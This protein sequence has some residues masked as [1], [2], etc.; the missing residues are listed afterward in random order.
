STRLPAVEQFG[1]GLF[2]TG[3]RN[4]LQGCLARPQVQNRI[5]AL[6][7]AADRWLEQRRQ[8]G[9][10]I[11][12]HPIRDQIRPEY[13]L[14]HAEIAIDCGYPAS[15][16]YERIYN[17]QGFCGV[18]PAVGILFYITSAETRAPLGGLVE[19]SCRFAQVLE[20]AVE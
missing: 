17:L 16:I 18:A 8:R 15:S 10:N 11:S 13:F 5:A 4:A 1:E 7:L 20:N 14:A 12:D 19:V 2:L 3:D 9:E 6:R